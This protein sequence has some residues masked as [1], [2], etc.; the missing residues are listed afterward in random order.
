V[1]RTEHYRVIRSRTIVDNSVASVATGTA[2]ARI[3]GLHGSLSMLVGL[4]YVPR[5]NHD[6]AAGFAGNAFS[7]YGR[8]RN[9]DG[10]SVPLLTAATINGT[11]SGQDA[12]DLW[13]GETNLH[14]LDLVFAYTGINSAADVG[15]WQV[16]VGA[17]PAFEMCEADF[18]S[19]AADLDV[20]L[21]RVIVLA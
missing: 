21:D 6:V 18:L 10:V 4:I 2:R 20:Q 8:A 3:V 16:L 13:E 14:E 7:L 17:V 11:G 1:K 12:P 5:T 15:S 9:E 19:L